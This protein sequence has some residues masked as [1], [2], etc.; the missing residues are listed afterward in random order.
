MEIQTLFNK[1]TKYIFI[2]DNKFVIR[3]SRQF[4][5]AAIWICK[6]TLL[7]KLFLQI[8][9]LA[10]EQNSYFYKSKLSFIQMKVVN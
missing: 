5:I 8:A 6:I 4:Y 2:K 1:K 3:Y 7:S 10:H 9:L